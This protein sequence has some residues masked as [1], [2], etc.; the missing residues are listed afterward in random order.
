MLE[1]T[2]NNFGAQL[3]EL[4][5]YQSDKEIV[6]NGSI[7]FERPNEEFNKAKV[8]E[9]YVPDL[10][11]PASGISSC[12]LV[13]EI[14][15]ECFVTTLKTWIK[16]KNTICFE[17]LEP[18]GDQAYGNMI[19]IASLYVPKGQRKQF[20]VGQKLEINPVSQN[21]DNQLRYAVCYLDENWAMLALAYNRYFNPGKDVAEQILIEGLPADVEGELMFVGD[22]INCPYAG[23]P[24]MIASVQ[25]SVLK[26]SPITYTW[27]GDPNNSFFYGVLL[28]KKTE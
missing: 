8:L 16:D 2:G 28:R 4:E 24:A 6:I 22:D 15:N 18:W 20:T 7:V 21:S 25:N 27:G 19:S 13:G 14:D 23:A 12:F 26:V 9:V 1:S 3:I 17:K 10:S 11:I 5:T